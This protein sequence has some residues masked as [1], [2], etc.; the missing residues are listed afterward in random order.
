MW[1]SS[2]LLFLAISAVT[3]EK[4]NSKIGFENIGTFRK[5]FI[6]LRLN[7]NLNNVILK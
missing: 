3:A 6:S 7:K 1:K 5:Y 4:L 2:C